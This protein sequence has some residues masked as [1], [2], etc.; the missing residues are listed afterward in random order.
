MKSMQVQGSQAWLRGGWLLIHVAGIEPPG[1][2]GNEGLLRMH[3][4]GRKRLASKLEL[5]LLAALSAGQIQVERPKGKVRVTYVR[6][7]R[8]NAMDEDNLA[9]SLKP[10]LD[11]LV[12]IGVLVDDSPERLEIACLQRKRG[13]QGQ[14]F[15]LRIEP[16]SDSQ[17]GFSIPATLG[18]E[19]VVNHL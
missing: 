16:L 2:N 18:Q 6:S 12:R 8:A 9:A 5:M 11:A 7:Y 3:W 13:D 4:A 17:A 1:L 15:Q 14:H 19:G 10:V